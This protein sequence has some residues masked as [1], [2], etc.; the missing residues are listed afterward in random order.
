[1]E[2][3]ELEGLKEEKTRSYNRFEAHGK[4]FIDVFDSGIPEIESL[5][6]SADEIYEASDVERKVFT[7]ESGNRIFTSIYN[8][9][10]DAD[11]LTAFH[12]SQPY[13]INTEEYDKEKLIEAWEHVSGEKYED[14]LETET[15]YE[16]LKD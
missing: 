3:P 4:E 1:M 13:E 10:C 8:L 16:S 12:N 11:I 5:W 9:L 6:T 2:F 14:L 7:E 15:F